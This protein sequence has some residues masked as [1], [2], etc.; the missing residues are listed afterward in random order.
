MSYLLYIECNDPSEDALNVFIN[1]AKKKFPLLILT[2]R[3]NLIIAQKCKRGLNS[4]CIAMATD[5]LRLFC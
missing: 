4:T 3:K 1:L 5:C 2:I